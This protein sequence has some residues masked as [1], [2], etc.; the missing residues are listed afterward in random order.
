[1]SK[2]D[3]TLVGNT[4]LVIRQGPTSALMP[5]EIIRYP[6]NQLQPVKVREHVAPVT[7]GFHVSLRG[8]FGPTSKLAIAYAAFSYVGKN[9]KKQKNNFS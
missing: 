4:E 6:I 2:F 1:M 9:K 5:L 3:P 7:S 8:M